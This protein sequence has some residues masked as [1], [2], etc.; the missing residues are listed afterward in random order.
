MDCRI[1]TVSSTPYAIAPTFTSSRISRRHLYTPHHPLPSPS[2]ARPWARAATN[3]WA[4]GHLDLRPRRHVPR[5]LHLPVPPPHPFCGHQQHLEPKPRQRS[6]P[7]PR[8]HDIPH[9]RPHSHPRELAEI[10][11]GQCPK[12]FTIYYLLLREYLLFTIER[13]YIYCRVERG[14]YRVHCENL[15]PSSGQGWHC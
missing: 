7:H 12:V 11:K 1:R 9:Q 15:R 8:L 5:L 14:H 10:L 4:A 3:P 6:I 2:A 13:H